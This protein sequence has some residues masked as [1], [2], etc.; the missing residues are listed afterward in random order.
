[1]GSAKPVVFERGKLA[2]QKSAQARLPGTD[3]LEPDA[4]VVVGYRLKSLTKRKAAG[5]RKGTDGLN[6]NLPTQHAV[7]QALDNLV[8][9]NASVASL[10]GQDFSAT[11]IEM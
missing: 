2:A 5:S 8:V 10:C 6:L 1:M 4:L 7:A 3:C 9:T 11:I